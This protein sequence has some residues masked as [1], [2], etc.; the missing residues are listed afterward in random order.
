[1]AEIRGEKLNFGRKDIVPLHELP[2]AQ[3]EDPIIV[4]C[5]PMRSHARRI[6][7]TGLLF[8]IL[9]LLAIGSAVLAIEGGAVDS[10]LS[11]RAQ[12]A[13]N[14]AI[15]PRYVASVGS[16]AIRFDSG[17]RLAI[18]AR[19]VDIVEQASGEHLSKAGALRLALNPLSLLAGQVAISNI[20]AQDIRLETAQLPQGDP[21]PLSEVRIDKMPGLLEQ[22]FQRL[23][24]V[25]GL[26]Q[27]TGTKSI[28][29]ADIQIVLPAAPGQNP[30]QVTVNELRLGENVAGEVE[31]N[32]TVSV[33]G[34]KAT[35]F[36]GSGTVD[37][38]TTS[39]SAKLSGLEVT[40][41]L[42]KLDDHGMPREGLDS[43]LDL[44]L[45]AI[46]ARETTSPVISAVLR[47]SPGRVFFDGI[48][49]EFSGANVNLAYDFQKNSLE[50]LKSQ[51]QF[52][53]TLVPFSGAVI[54]LNRLNAADDRAGFG[55][56]VL[57]SGGTAVGSPDEA[58]APFDLKAVGRYLSVSRELQFDD[59]AVT[60]PL[61]RM[62][63]ALKIR[64]GKDSPE[65]SFGAQLP[66]MQVTGVK[67][68]WPYWMARKPRDWV[69]KNLFGGG[70]Q[71][72]SIAVFIPAGR[73][74]GPGVPLELDSNELRVA[75]D[76][77][78]GRLNLPGDMPPL[79]DINAH[80][81]LKGEAMQVDIAK[82]ASYL[83][84]G[85]TVS[86][87]GGRFSIGSTYTKPLM[88]DVALKLSGNA[89]ALTE[90][91]D[92]KPLNA[93]R[94]TDFKPTDFVGAGK[95]D[96][97]AHLGLISDQH[98]PKT[99]W[100]A[101]VSL[102]NVDLVPQ[103]EGRKI[104][105][106]VG[107]LD[108]DPQAA[109]LSAK[110]AIDGI[111]ADLTLVQPVDQNSTVKR[112]Q[113]VKATLSNDQR[114]KLVPGLSDVIEGPV[115]LELTRLDD[116]RQG[117]QLDL[118]KATLSVPWIGWTKGGGI[119][120]KAQMEVSGMGTDR[121]DIRNFVLDG[122]GFGAKGNLALS[123]GSLTS[124]D[125]TDTHLSPSDNF[126]VS[127]KHGKGIYDIS[128]GGSSADI[129]PIIT[130]LRADTGSSGSKIS[131]KESGGATLR[132]KLDKM[133]GFNDETL[134]NVSVLYS[135]RDGAITTA[136]L[137][138]VTE[139]GQAIVSQMNRGQTISVTSGDAGALVRFGNIYTNMRGGLLNLKL[140]A[141]GSDWQG[142]IDIRGFS[143]VDEQRLKSLASTPV[144]SDGQTLASKRGIDVSQ[145]K[146]QRGYAAL[147]YRNGTLS[148][149][150]GVVRG[151]QIGATFQGML[152][153][154][155]GNMQMTGTFMPAYGLNRLF[156]E[157]PLIGTILG[158]GNDRGLL[159]ITFKLEG[160]FDK[161]KLS[162]NPL[163]IIA[164]GVF[165][166]IFEFQ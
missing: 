28:R 161:P 104:T 79:R 141:L 40:S 123:G 4:H 126:T 38:V 157:L 93:L 56:D 152:R 132:A 151:E 51:A 27:R 116:K 62:A 86:L 90:L 88:A 136:D 82:A 164:P 135:V 43:A 102:D 108:V 12:T 95:V 1:M 85:K 8:L 115:G 118:S 59:M 44:Q 158:N 103:M 143:L 153:D 71:N 2:S 20:E 94:G 48:E 67:Q 78:D 166:Q 155:N 84:S 63:G 7:K 25:R 111:P 159:G 117:V 16:A 13:L 30:I 6:G 36:A 18:E 10:T 97:K 146:F 127:I 3:A 74:K 154:A 160:Q 133:V 35:L 91:A 21:L 76:L 144:G 119:G 37:G 70:V 66:Q 17:F 19:D 64:F 138:A 131:G 122:E 105:N 112:E 60:S 110:A 130:K 156:G 73:M 68:L 99:V 65:I 33:N 89:D 42:L 114:E 9:I 47:Q 34:R 81:D 69:M 142:A 137:S 24:E 113:V 29:L 92:F 120:A 57:V 109:R 106:V 75:F 100:S 98:P 46:R 61:G 121:T 32:G 31:V 14:N 15:G 162:I 96:V 129:R 11:S 87:D 77:T 22:A 5:P 83:P 150:N 125:F 41:F 107:T 128:V 50:I 39:L 165:R 58:P 139:S 101:H 124:A 134:S 54:D 80:F 148:V 49:Q 23:D 52:G 163:S 53:P 140:K 55:L 45:S 26:I 149:D 147:A 145:A 72:A